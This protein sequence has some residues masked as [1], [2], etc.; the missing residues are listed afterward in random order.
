MG[1]GEEFL[2][3]EPT[4]M[5]IIHAMCEDHNW[6]IRRWNAQYLAEFLNVEMYRTKNI[7]QQLNKSA[8]PQIEMNKRERF[9][10]KGV[11]S[12]EMMNSGEIKEE[13]NFF[14]EVN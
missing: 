14:E 13:V 4:F 3:L 11:G 1:K 5:K 12:F 7:M 8:M 9:Q 10:S 2:R 6:H